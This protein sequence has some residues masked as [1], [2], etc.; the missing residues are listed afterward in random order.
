MKTITT[1]RTILAIA[2]VA[3][4]VAYGVV[5]CDKPASPGPVKLN[6]N[7]ATEVGN[8]VAEN[9][10]AVEWIKTSADPSATSTTAETVVGLVGPGPV[11]IPIGSC[12]FAPTAAMTGV[13]GGNYATIQVFRRFGPDGGGGT[14]QKVLAQANVTTALTAFTPVTIPIVTD[15]GYPYVAPSD[16][17]TV[18]ISKT[19]TG[20]TLPSGDLSCFQTIQ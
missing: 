12:Q 19:G 7:N 4:V 3:P 13:D 14:S 15:A 17:L 9:N 20:G 8:V 18:Q 11:N 10:P 5:A 16:V 2:V 6:V 1:L